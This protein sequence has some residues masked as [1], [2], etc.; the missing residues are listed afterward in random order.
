MNE[1]EV[2]GPVTKTKKN[3]KKP[4]ARAA[5]KRDDR[6]RCL[7]CGLAVSKTPY[8]RWKHNANRQTGPG[9]GEEPEIEGEPTREA[10]ANE[11]LEPS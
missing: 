7:R 1:V 4:A 6:P 11:L 10:I 3:T 2:G 9:C 5:K 8:G